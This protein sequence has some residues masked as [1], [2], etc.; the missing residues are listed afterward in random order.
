MAISTVLLAAV[1]GG[2]EGS[3]LPRSA[4]EDGFRVFGGEAG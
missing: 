4:C 3:G 2:G 1:L